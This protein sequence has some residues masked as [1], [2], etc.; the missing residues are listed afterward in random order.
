[1]SR[2][3]WALTCLS[4][5]GGILLRASSLDSTPLQSDEAV[6]WYL[7]RA[8]SSGTFQYDPTQFHGPLFFRLLN[9][10]GIESEA[11]LRSLS[12]GAGSL[13]VILPFLLT[14]FFGAARCAGVAV[15]LAFDPLLIYYSRVA[16][17]ESLFSLLSALCLVFMFRWIHTGGRTAITVVGV[18]LGLLAATKETFALPLTA[19]VIALT[20]LF[21]Q[22]LRSIRI[23]DLL[24]A[25]TTAL[26][27]TIWGYDRL[28]GPMELLRGVIAWTETGIGESTQTQPW[29][30]F[31]ALL[32]S[33]SPLAL[34]GLTRFFSPNRNVRF[35][36]VYGLLLLV[37]YSIIPYKT[38]WLLCTV[39]FP[40]YLT[41]AA[42][43]SNKTLLGGIVCLQ[44]LL[45]LFANNTTQLRANS[46][47]EEARVLSHDILQH[48]NVVGPR[49]RV[50][51]GAQWYWPLPFY[52]RSIE[53][54]TLYSQKPLALP[55]EDFHVVVLPGS[56]VRDIP[57]WTRR[58]V[59]LSRLQSVTAL[60]APPGEIK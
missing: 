1:M 9:L 55:L 37:F 57:G 28:D 23:L 5:M 36:A 19:T 53:T 18:S 15:L 35:V 20:L 52:L 33:I 16:I 38:P 21:P 10:L 51:I 2:A 34:L 56:E 39:L 44:I 13:I 27:L 58:T 12:V 46:T 7:A 45:A 3:A 30:Y 6:N 47:S 17:H 59:E 50:F 14:P 31:G 48:C 22:K 43:V 29:W 32:F 4:L 49:C 42:S 25:V 24:I 8:W 41:I 26:A 54:Q 11:S 60:F 40:L